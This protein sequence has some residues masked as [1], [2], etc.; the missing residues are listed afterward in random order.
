MAKLKSAYG[1]RVKPVI[2]RDLDDVDKTIEVASQH[3]FVINTTLGFHPESAAALVHGL[4]KRKHATGKDVFMIHTSGTSNMADRPIT[5]QYVETE[6]RVFDDEKDDIYGY[7]KK[8]NE[9]Q[10]YMQ[11]TSELGVIDASLKTGVKTLVI[12]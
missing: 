12:M 1:Q 11:R 8:R 9:E 3:D 10:P 5:K 4:A 7:E 2:Y 6:G